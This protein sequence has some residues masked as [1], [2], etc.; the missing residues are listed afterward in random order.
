M[1]FYQV[2]SKKQTD[3]SILIFHEIVNEFQ[4]TALNL[5]KDSKLFSYL[6]KNIFDISFAD[7]DVKS[8]F[9]NICKKNREKTKKR[10][11]KKLKINKKSIEAV[12]LSE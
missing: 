4:T 8:V 2:I 3:D 7:E 10:N 11:I 12:N 9:K 6:M 1:N 5:A